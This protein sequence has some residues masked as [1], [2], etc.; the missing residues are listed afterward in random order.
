MKNVVKRFKT[1][2][3]A[4]A[5]MATLGAATDAKA[6]DFGNGDLVLAVFGN[7]TQYLQNLGQAGSLFTP[8]ST[9]TLNIGAS[10]VTA[11]SGSL[12]VNWALVSFT[13]DVD[14]GDPTVLVASASKNLSAFTPL[15][16]ASVSVINPWIAAGSW[17]GQLSAVPGSSQQILASDANSYT[18][19]FGTDGSMASGFPISTQGL[20]NSVLAVLQGTPFTNTLAQLGSATL[21]ADGTLTLSGIP[22][23][24]PVPVPAAVVLFGTGLAG[25]VGV[26]RRKLIAA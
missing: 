11:V 6:L 15:E 19:T 7:S 5:M 26:A 10:N 20:F 23:T 1:A 21:L 18:N 22:G 12:P 14:S 25:L 16:L 24:A 17:A 13:Y 8:G 2:V 3:V 4:A 9:T